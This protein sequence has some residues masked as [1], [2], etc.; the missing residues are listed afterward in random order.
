MDDEPRLPDGGPG[1]STGTGSGS[2]AGTGAGTGNGSA[3]GTDSVDARRVAAWLRESLDPD[4][5]SAAVSKLPGGHS[6]GVWRVDAVIDGDVR[7]MILKAPELPSVVYQ[8]DACREARILAAVHGMG[9]PVP[10]VLAVDTGTATGRRCFVMEHVEG[11][12]L[13]DSSLAGPHE[14]AWLRDMGPD[15]RRAV[16]DSFHDALGALHSVDA[17]KV[18]DA[19]HGQRGVVDVLDYWRAALLDAAPAPSVPRQLSALD[20]LRD[21]VPPGAD[22]APAVCMGDARI[23]NCLLAGTEARALVDFEVAYVGNPAADVAY[24]VFFDGLH[25]AGAQ[26]PLDGLPS[27]AE[28]WDRW[29]RATGRPADGLAYWTAFGVTILCVTATRAMIQ[30]GLADQGIESAN[31]MVARWEA[32]VERA[33]HA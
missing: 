23:A 19:S 2:G 28:T 1:A 20:W 3:I 8:R 5:S 7:P 12:G 14:D 4:V 18:P 17:R 24:S 32:C 15:A 29:S 25:R 10:A 11:H 9:A 31:P 6:S 30:W 13:A 16:W 33:A 22:D 27:A 21:H 26:Q